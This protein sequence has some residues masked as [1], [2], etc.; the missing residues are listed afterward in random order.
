MHKSKEITMYITVA[1]NGLGKMRAELSKL[2]QANIFETP[3]NC[4]IGILP[5][6]F[7]NSVTKIKKSCTS[8]KKDDWMEVLHDY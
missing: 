6:P 8:I 7:I 4:P 1:G 5:C 3:E 2:C